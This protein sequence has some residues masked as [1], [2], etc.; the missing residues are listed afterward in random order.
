MYPESEIVSLKPNKDLDYFLELFSQK[1][2]QIFI[3]GPY[4]LGDSPG[5]IQYFGKGKHQGKVVIGLGHA[6]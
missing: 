5:L 6:E 3:D 2:I 1:K 4:L